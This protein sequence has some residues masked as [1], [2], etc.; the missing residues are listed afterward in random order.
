ML[1]RQIAV[2][3]MQNFVYLLADQETREAIAVDSG[4]ETRPIINRVEL[5][6]LS[7]KF[8][9][10]THDHYDHVGTLEELATKLGALTVSHEGSTVS[11]GMKVKDGHELHLGAETVKILHTPGHTPDSICLYDGK[12]LFTG[13]TLFIGA[14]GRTDL[15]G[16][17]TE[18]LFRSIHE[19]IMKLPRDTII[20]PGHDYGEVPSRTLTEE[21]KSNPA[22]LARSVEEFLG[23]VGQ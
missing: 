22:L 16:G 8:V 13:D 12:N 4:W 18:E 10:A 19:V 5:D 14:W 2:G 17:S 21:M 11:G 23:M 6:G 15:P 20:F 7:V 3:P 9:V 1:V